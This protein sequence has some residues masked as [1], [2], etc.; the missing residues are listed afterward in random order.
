MLSEVKSCMSVFQYI[1]R[2]ASTGSG[3]LPPTASTLSR[4]SN[5]FS[6]ESNV[7]M[8]LKIERFFVLSK[9]KLE[10]KHK[11]IFIFLMN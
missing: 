10:I 1:D 11:R 5:F 9:Q 7:D 4:V 6:E 2:E 3:S 8:L